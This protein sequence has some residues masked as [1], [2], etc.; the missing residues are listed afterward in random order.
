MIYAQIKLGH[1]SFC[2]NIESANKYV[3]TEFISRQQTDDTNIQ[4]IELTI[5]D[6]IMHATTNTN[7]QHA[8][9]TFFKFYLSFIVITLCHVLTTVW[10]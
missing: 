1:Q 6:I 3:H 9:I 7:Y 10:R 5:M 4:W 8:M 2:V